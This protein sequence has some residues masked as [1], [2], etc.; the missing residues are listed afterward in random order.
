MI[1]GSAARNRTA[2]SVGKC[3]HDCT[4]KIQPSH[5]VWVLVLCGQVA[6][7]VYQYSFPQRSE[8]STVRYPASEEHTRSI[9]VL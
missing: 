2:L 4:F 1:S 5:Y 3:G 9:R 8:A 7:T 6:S